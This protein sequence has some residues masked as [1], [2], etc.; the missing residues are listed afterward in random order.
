MAASCDR[1]VCQVCRAARCHSCPVALMQPR[2]PH[3]AVLCPVLR[4]TGCATTRSCALLWEGMSWPKPGGCGCVRVWL[5]CTLR[6]SHCSCRLQGPCLVQMLLKSCSAAVQRDEVGR[7]NSVVACHVAVCVQGPQ[8][9]ISAVCS[10]QV[11]RPG[12]NHKGPRFESRAITNWGHPLP[13]C[14]RC[15]KLAALLCHAV[16]WVPSGQAS[17]ESAYSEDC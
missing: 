1:N 15:L 3:T 6:P 11:G 8:A 9:G 12:S 16:L 17:K 4:A 2:Q 10:C 14:C 5:C 7:H 13:A